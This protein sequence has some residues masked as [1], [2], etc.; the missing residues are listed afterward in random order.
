MRLAYISI[1]MALTACGAQDDGSSRT[2]TYSSS[3]PSPSVTAAPTSSSSPTASPSPSPSSSNEPFGKGNLTLTFPSLPEQQSSTSP[4]LRIELTPSA[5]GVKGLKLD[6]NA[7]RSVQIS[8]R[9]A[10]DY[11]VVA[12]LIEKPETVLSKG[13]AKV[14]IKASET[15]ATVI[16]LTK[17]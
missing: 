8:D 10:G 4:F 2:Y 7:K 11:A 5:S 17:Q 12:R 13:E 16:E 9:A 15:A 14:T 3:S 1:Y 6:T